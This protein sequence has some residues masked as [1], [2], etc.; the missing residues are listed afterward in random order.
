MNIGVFT[1]TYLPSHDGV[2]TSIVDFR[3][4]L[5]QRDH[6]FWVFAPYVPPRAEGDEVPKEDS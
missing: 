5:E 6:K 2:V 3:R 1:D 4:E